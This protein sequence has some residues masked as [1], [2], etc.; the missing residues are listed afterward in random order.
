MIE[1]PSS[2]SIFWIVGAGL[3]IGIWWVARHSESR[4]PCLIMV[5]RLILIVCGVRQ[6][7]EIDCRRL[8]FQMFAIILLIWITILAIF[9]PTQAHRNGLV[10]IGFIVESVGLILFDIVLS[11]AN[12]RSTRE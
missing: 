5:P 1:M 6:G 11:R 8:E 4:P 2:S 3:S 12:K 7:N 9:V 10:A